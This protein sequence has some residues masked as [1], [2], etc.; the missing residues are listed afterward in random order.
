MP[1][2]WPERTTKHE[3]ASSNDASFELQSRRVKAAWIDIVVA[4]TIVL[5]F[6]RL[7]GLKGKPEHITTTVN[8]KTTSTTIPGPTASDWWLWASAATILLYYLLTELLTG[9]TLGKRLMGCV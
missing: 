1:E 2:D 7:F 3:S 5:A 9:Q 4:V 6:E 8:G